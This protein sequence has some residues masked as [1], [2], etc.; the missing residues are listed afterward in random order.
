MQNKR[1]RRSKSHKY[2]AIFRFISQKLIEVKNQ[3]H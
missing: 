2:E 3:D 1:V